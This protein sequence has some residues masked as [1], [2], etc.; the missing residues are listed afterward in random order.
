MSCDELLS[1]ETAFERTH[2]P[3]NL[4]HWQGVNNMAT[5]VSGASLPKNA[6]EDHRMFHMF[7]QSG[8]SYIENKNASF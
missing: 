7:Q 1:S 8:L 6:E 2:C 4:S 5:F 3:T